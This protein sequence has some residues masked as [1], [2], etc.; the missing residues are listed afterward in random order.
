MPVHAGAGRGLQTDAGG[1]P[2]SRHVV[3]HY[4]GAMRVARELGEGQTI[5]TSFGRERN[6]SERVVTA[7]QSSVATA[8]S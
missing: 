4:R 3:R 6:R 7:S 8:A 2:V 5:V 1:G